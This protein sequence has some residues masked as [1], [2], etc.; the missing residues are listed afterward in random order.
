MLTT[1]DLGKRYQLTHKQVRSLVDTVSPL[2]ADGVARGPH[3]TI[4]IK[5][6]AIPVFDRAMDLRREGA[7]W[8]S[9][10]EQ[11]NREMTDLFNGSGA[12]GTPAGGPAM[13][14]QP[15]GKRANSDPPKG[16][17]TTAELIAA[18]KD[19]IQELKQDKEF[20]QERV[21]QLEVLAL[22]ANSQGRLSRWR[23]LRAVFLGR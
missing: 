19:Q 18:L 10:E 7:S 16:N 1:S 14:E 20:L 22:P 3:N 17:E 13:G 2:L 12:N 5:E 6:T 9:I 15:P 21:K 4:L 8:P 23:H 11:L